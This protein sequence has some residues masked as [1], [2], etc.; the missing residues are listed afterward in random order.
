MWLELNSYDRNLLSA[1][2][3]GRVDIWDTADFRIIKTFF[4]H[5]G[6]I[7]KTMTF[8]QLDMIYTCC[9]TS[10]DSYVRV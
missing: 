7:P 10:Q 2:D 1:S 8:G 5:K 3:K 6:Q 9:Q 4:P